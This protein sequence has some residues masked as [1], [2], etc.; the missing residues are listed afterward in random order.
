MHSTSA[1]MLRTGPERCN[2]IGSSREGA[3]QVSK[4]ATPPVWGERHAPHSQGQ[5][6]H[7]DCGE[8]LS[9]VPMPGVA[10]IHG[11][12]ILKQ[13]E[14]DKLPRHQNPSAQQCHPSQLL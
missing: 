3:V 13:I 9:E 5:Q 2:Q 8:A 1:L 6:R 14:L 4:E 7:S 10:T 11:A 12:A